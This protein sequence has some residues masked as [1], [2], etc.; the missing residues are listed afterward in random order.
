[1]GNFLILGV[2]LDQLANRD[3]LTVV[4]RPR[5]D[6]QEVLI[7]RI[8]TA[9]SSRERLEPWTLADIAP[10]AGL[11]PAGLL[12]RFGSR[13]GILL[14]LSRR[15][16]DSIPDDPQDASPVEEELRA[17]VARRFGSGGA[18]AVAYGLVNLIDDLVDEDLR[19]LLAE[20][21]AK[22]T[23]Y[24]ASLLERLKLRGL[25]DQVAG[26]SVL[27]DALNGAML[28]SA[29]QA[30]PFVATRTLDQLLEAWT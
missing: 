18:H 4:A 30:D 16:I 28:R 29:A 13:N 23:R 12:K 21:W 25:S 11:S 15:W 17:W 10:T 19:Q 14:A 1:M 26:A 22:E 7:D 20:G 6:E 5:R 3:L 2:A 9:L 24:I 27:F 8:A